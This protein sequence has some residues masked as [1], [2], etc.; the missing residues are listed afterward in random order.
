MRTRPP[1]PSATASHR[2]VRDA[3]ESGVSSAS[4]RASRIDMRYLIHAL[5]KYN[6]SDLHIRVGRPPLYRINGKIVPTR[7]AELT[8]GQA[9][10]I[11]H[12][13]LTDKQ[14]QELH[15]K[16][17]IDF[18]FRMKDF[19]RF[20]CNVFFQRGTIGAAV[21]MIPLTVPGFDTLGIPSVLKELC[22]R[23][24]GLLLVTGATGSGK[25]TTLASLIQHINE[26]CYVHVLAI[27]DPIEFVYRDQKATITQRE[28]GSDTPSLEAGLHAGLRQ[29]PDVIMIGE[30]RDYR[31]IQAA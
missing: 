14:I 24:R 31:T 20:R 8:Q 10:Q 6:A 19:G 4:N 5:I 26:T 9:E 3:T 13:V 23:P 2:Y 28:V 21:R 11:L 1:P 7:M 16:R 22:K 25:S 18:S 29:D 15:E 27:E 30:L 17:T 12:G